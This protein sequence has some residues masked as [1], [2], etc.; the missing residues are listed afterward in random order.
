MRL[1]ELEKFKK[2]DLPLAV[3]VE[4][5]TILYQL[6]HWHDCNEMVLICEGTGWCAVNDRKFPMLRGDLY[7]MG[8]SDVHE[9]SGNPGLTF[10]NIMFSEDF[11]SEDEKSFFGSLLKKHEKY[12]FP[13]AL[14][15]R[16]IALLTAVVSEIKNRR[17]GAEIIIRSLFIQFLVEVTRN[18]GNADA[19]ASGKEFKRVS[20]MFDLIARRFRE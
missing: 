7:I 9:F 1:Y 17:P 11:F 16:L 13:P 8:A 18:L 10:F 19:I 5:P 2:T 12:T 6:P 14:G 3:W 4:C 20:R 15:N